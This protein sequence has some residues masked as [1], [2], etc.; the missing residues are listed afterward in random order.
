MCPRNWNLEGV[1]ALEVRTKRSELTMLRSD[2]SWIPDACRFD[3]LFIYVHRNLHNKSKNTP[4]IL[5]KLFKRRSLKVYDV[6]QKSIMLASGTK[7][8]IFQV[9]LKYL[10]QVLFERLR[11]WQVF[12]QYFTA[13]S[14]TFC[15]LNKTVGI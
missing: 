4:E 10:P 14:K 12:W 3:R 6:F 8:I 9:L 13:F 15:V 2:N 1:T 5:L 7:L 11:E